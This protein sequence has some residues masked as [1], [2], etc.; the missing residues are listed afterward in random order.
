M[1]GRITTQL[2]ARNKLNLFWD[3]QHPCNGATWTPQG[4]GCRVPTGNAVFSAGAPTSP[5]AVGYAQRFQRVPQ[6]TWSS[7]ATNGLLLEAGVG[8]SLSRWGTNR[9]P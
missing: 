7:P 4:Q 9:R 5:H 8:T 1:S 2:S 6:A 3:E